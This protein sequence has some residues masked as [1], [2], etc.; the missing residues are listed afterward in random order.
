M[1]THMYTCMYIHTHAYIKISRLCVAQL[2][3]HTGTPAHARALMSAHTRARA[4]AVPPRTT[5]R[6]ASNTRRAHPACGGAPPGRKRR[7]IH[8]RTW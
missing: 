8:W 5:A 2:Y 3:L 1:C 7:R 4:S 6:A